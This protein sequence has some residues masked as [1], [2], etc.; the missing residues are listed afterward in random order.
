MFEWKPAYSVQI[1][2]ID[3]EHRNLFAIGRELHA[4]I[5]AGHGTKSISGILDRLLQ[6]TAVHF[7]H[8]ERLLE[9]HAYPGLAA[10]RIEHQALTE[11]VVEFRRAFDEGRAAMSVQVLQFLRDWFDHH[12]KGSD[13]HYAPYLRERAVA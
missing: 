6:Y 9:L 5:S 4:A 1:H 2:S 3:N 11:R 13:H 7:A 10:H 8:E 12:I